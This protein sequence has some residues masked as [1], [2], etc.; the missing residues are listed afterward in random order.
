MLSRDAPS[1]ESSRARPT[2][3]HEC[4][5]AQRSAQGRC[6]GKEESRGPE[7]SV[8]RACS[9][10]RGIVETEVQ[11]EARVLTWQKNRNRAPQ[12]RR[13]EKRHR[14]ARKSLKRSG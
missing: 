5:N 1:A 14:S 9:A 7:V 10:F 12:Q 3:A 4:A 11:I 8:R 2:H 13:R 6:R